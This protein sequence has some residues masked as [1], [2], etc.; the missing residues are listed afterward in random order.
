M[1]S[2]MAKYPTTFGND[3]FSNIGNL[4]WFQSP[5]QIDS[6]ASVITDLIMAMRPRLESGITYVY[7]IGHTGR[8]YKIQVNDP[9]SYNPAVNSPTLLA[10]LVI[11]SPT[12]K[13]GS[14]IQFYGS[15]EKLFIGH[16]KGVTKINFDGTNE[17]FVGTLGSYTANVP[18]PSNNFTGKLYFGNGNNLL[19]ID[20]TETVTTY[21]TLSPAFPSGTYVRD[22]DI[23]IDGN[24]LQIVVSRLT[25]PDMTSTTQDTNSLST[26]DSYKFLWNGSDAGYTSFETFN[27]YSLNTN[28]TFGSNS[29]TMGFDLGGGAIYLNGDKEITLPNFL[30]PNFASMWSSGNM[31]GFIAP[32]LNNGFM[33]ASMMQFGQYDYETTKGLFRNFTMAATSPETDIIQVPCS[34]IVSNLLFGASSN[35]YAGNQVGTPQLFFSTLETSAAPTTQYRFYSFNTYPTPNTRS[36]GTTGFIPGVYE[37]QQETSLKLFRNI[38]SRKFKP[39]QVRLY[40]QQSAN[41]TFP[42]K[43]TIDLI[44]SDGTPMNGGSKTFTMTGSLL[45][46]DFVWYTPATQPT[47]SLGVRITNV[48]GANWVGEKLEVEY[49]EA[50]V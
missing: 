27:S 29:Y 33:K 22:L 25:P 24:Y 42:A 11:N 46:N 6:G 18:R 19:T 15:T 37:T 10:T 32:E 16:D 7:A 9:T 2:G 3:P 14:S 5:V 28:T 31:L 44:G 45:H 8:L 34:G 4:T 47:Y 13:Y 30:S 43:F 48:N 36:F 23:S 26:A 21:A 40:L 39:T 49:E 12:F 50:G 41:V 38:I 1:N 17:T 35:G 20:S